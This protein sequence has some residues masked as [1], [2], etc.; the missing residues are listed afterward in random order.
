M[1]KASIG[2]IIAEN[3]HEFLKNKKNE[4]QLEDFRDRFDR[5]LTPNG[6]IYGIL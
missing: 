4:K 6:S 3:E 5:R 2:V 1:T